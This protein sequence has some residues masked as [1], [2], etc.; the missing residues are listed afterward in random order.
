[1]YL[2]S[3]VSD[4]PDPLRW[5]PLRTGAGVDLRAMQ[6]PGE[7]TPCPWVYAVESVVCDAPRP[8]TTRREEHGKAAESG[9]DL[10]RVVAR[11]EQPEG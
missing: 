10:V 2:E 5:M 7:D 8:E 3:Y 9:R 4:V 6:V 1:M 11:G